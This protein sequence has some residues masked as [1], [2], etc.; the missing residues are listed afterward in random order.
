MSDSIVSTRMPTTLMKEL[1]EK[2]EKEHYM[3]VSDA[4]RSVLKQKSSEYWRTDKAFAGNTLSA[5]E[6]I[7]G[8]KEILNQLHEAKE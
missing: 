1:K 6:L 4:V 8:L 2:A 3:D 7:K 5:E